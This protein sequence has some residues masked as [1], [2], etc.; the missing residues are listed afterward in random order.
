MEVHAHSH[1]PRRRW[2]HYFWEFFML[3]LAITLGFFV[4]NRR[5]HYIEGER[6]KEYAHTLLQDIVNDTVEMNNTIIRYQK[7]IVAIDS[8]LSYKEINSVN[9]IPGGAIYYYGLPALSAFRMS[10]NTATMEQLKFSGNLRYFRNIELKNKIGAYDNA[11]KNF[12]LRQDFEL[13]FSSNTQDY[14]KLFDYETINLMLHSID[15]PSFISNFIRTDH[16]LLS[17]D[18]VA[19]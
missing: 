10:F 2:T 6:A 8:L 5:E 15:N 16:P 12:M 11:V 4:E 7:N 9:T 17:K 3:F 19:V 18:P 1:T 14:L 13:G